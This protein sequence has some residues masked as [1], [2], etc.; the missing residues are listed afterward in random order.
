[1]TCL[2][3]TKHELPD[4]C[5]DLTDF[6]VNP[7]ECCTNKENQLSLSAWVQYKYFRRNNISTKYL[8]NTVKNT[9]NTYRHPKDRYNKS[10]TSLSKVAGENCP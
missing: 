10:T 6:C 4:G 2:C 3:E 1:M 9:E 8:K 5:V 7:E